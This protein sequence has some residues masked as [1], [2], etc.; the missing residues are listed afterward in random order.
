MLAPA[1]GGVLLVKQ[2]RFLQKCGRVGMRAPLEQCFALQ[3][4]STLRI[5]P[6]FL[7]M[8]LGA[9]VLLVL[10]PLGAPRHAEAAIAE[11]DGSFIVLTTKA[12]RLTVVCRLNADGSRAR[13]GAR[14]RSKGLRQARWRA[15][16]RV[17]PQRIQG[18]RRRALLRSAALAC[19]AARAELESA[20]PI[21]ESP[22]PT[23]TPS[24]T[25]SVPPLEVQPLLVPGDGWSGALVEPTPLG[26]PSDAAYGAKVI[27]RWS[28]IP[29]QTINSGEIAI[30]VVAFH[31]NGID[32]VHFSVN[33]G[34]WSAVSTMSLN[35]DTGVWEYV[36]RIRAEDFAPHSALEVRAIALPHGAGTPRLL[37]GPVQNSVK[38]GEHSL[39]FF[40][41]FPSP[42][43]RYV[44]TY[45]SDTSGS[46][47]ITQ[48]FR[49]VRRAFN[50]LTLPADDGA[51]IL[52][53]DQ[54]PD[55]WEILA[56]HI[57]GIYVDD[58]LMNQRWI[59]VAPASGLPKMRIAQRTGNEY[60]N[61]GMQRVK[62]EDLIIDFTRVYQLGS[63]AYTVALPDAMSA[64]WQ[65]RV[66][67]E[68]P[69]YGVERT[70]P[71]RGVES[72]AAWYTTNSLV[73]DHY[74]G[75]S[76][77]VLVRNSHA[78]RITGDL[79]TNTRIVLSSS[80]HHHI[81][82]CSSCN[83][84][85]DNFQYYGSQYYAG[86]Y[87]TPPGVHNGATWEGATKI[88]TANG[89]SQYGFPFVATP[90]HRLIVISGTGV[91]A[92]SYEIE[93]VLD[94][95]RVRLRESITGDGPPVD[96][97]TG[98]IYAV[99]TD[100]VDNIIVYGFEGSDLRDVQNWHYDYGNHRNHA[101]VNIALEN[102]EQTTTANGIGY[103]GATHILMQHVSLARKLTFFHEQM[104]LVKVV[105][106]VFES[107]AGI[108]S[109]DIPESVRVYS[110]HLN[111]LIGSSESQLSATTIGAPYQSGNVVGRDGIGSVLLHFDAPAP[112]GNPFH[113]GRDSGSLSSSGALIPGFTTLGSTTGEPPPDR[114]AYT[115]G[116]TPN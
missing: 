72:G 41:N 115:F 74:A 7:L 57:N 82:D 56:R 73:R 9:L 105:N 11:V 76:G 113:S 103:L 25:P 55:G 45:G 26:D 5:S 46:G 107:L 30:G 8:T 87:D 24:P 4:A 102:S 106:S 66:L 63:E 94:N 65:E 15:L 83:I 95:K 84:H 79:F 64:Y 49:T 40:A 12:A 116:A 1:Y 62:F 10:G 69:G 60:L 50:S 2:V 21:D 110:S 27:A 22:T 17:L 75:F 104:T 98:D 37:S 19:E 31:Y 101:F 109:D 52:L 34:P 108:V 91:V 3:R 78:E 47:S 6:T 59:T 67:W 89:G 14:V 80:A 36:A 90:D 61:P 70:N 114:G 16:A 39:F 20:P 85:P 38:N 68:G 13:A 81:G 54:D 88:L 77:H 96:L 100:L 33:N 58:Y 44:A 93:E 112:D 23:P 53:L 35:P 18:E 99:A 86:I 71:I 48:P 29:F 97:P 111:T 51:R 42:S 32:S 92:G 28:T 43:E